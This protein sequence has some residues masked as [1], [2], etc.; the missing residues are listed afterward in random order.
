MSGVDVEE[1][2][3]VPSPPDLREST[4]LVPSS[5]PPQ[6]ALFSQLL[7]QDGEPIRVPTVTRPQQFT[8]LLVSPIVG[9]VSAGGTNGWRIDRLLSPPKDSPQPL[10]V[11]TGMESFFTHSCLSH[12]LSAIDTIMANGNDGNAETGI[13]GQVT[14]LFTPEKKGVGGSEN[15]EGH[16]DSPPDQHERPPPP[17]KKRHSLGV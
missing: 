9:D 15:T 10:S 11:T 6:R 14:S 1:D 16:G 3:D 2:G 5:P 13:W 7:N 4:D 17:S 12:W 8:D